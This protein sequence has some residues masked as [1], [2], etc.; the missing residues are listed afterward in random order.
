MF[1]SQLIITSLAFLK[2][3]GVEIILGVTLAILGILLVK[4]IYELFFSRP[5]SNDEEMQIEDDPVGLSDMF[6]PDRDNGEEP[7]FSL[8]EFTRMRQYIDKKFVYSKEMKSW[9]NVNFLPDNIRNEVLK[10]L[11]PDEELTDEGLSDFNPESDDVT[12]DINRS[13][14]NVYIVESSEDE[15]DKKKKGSEKND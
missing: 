1:F 12:I 9:V 2:V 5:S 11:T 3:I 7:L 10:N 8:E 14:L 6:E 4:A 13:S 15:E